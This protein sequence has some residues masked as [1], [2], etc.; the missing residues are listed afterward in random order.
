MRDAVIRDCFRKRPVERYVTLKVICG[1]W[2]WKVQV[3]FYARTQ[4]RPVS[5]DK[6]THDIVCSDLGAP[7]VIDEQVEN[8]GLALHDSVIPCPVFPDRLERY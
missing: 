5:N 8:A 6:H 1:M 4:A 7:S 2:T 3:L